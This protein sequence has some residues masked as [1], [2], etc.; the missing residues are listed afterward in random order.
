MDNIDKRIKQINKQLAKIEK[1]NENMRLLDTVD[2]ARDAVEASSMYSAAELGFVDGI[3]QGFLTPFSLT[4]TIGEGI[5]FLREFGA[6][7]A[8]PIAL[9]CILTVPCA[10]IDIALAPVCWFHNFVT[11]LPG[12]LIANAII[13]HRKYKWQKKLPEVEKVVNNLKQEKENLLAKKENKREK[14][15]KNEKVVAEKELNQRSKS[16]TDLENMSGKEIAKYIVKSKK[17]KQSNSKKAE[18]KEETL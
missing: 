3:K 17:A 6:Y 2:Y 5:D 16:T 11:M 7:A 9:L 8:I 18:E 14:E 13:K 4:F 15:D 1:K 12:H 10:I